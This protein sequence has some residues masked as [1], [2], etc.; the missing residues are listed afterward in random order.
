MEWINYHHLLYFWVVAREGGLVPAGK[1]LNLSHPTLSTQIRSLEAALDEKLF[2]K[3]GRKLTLTESGRI[4]FRYAEEIF[5]LG[6][7]MVDTLKGRSSGQPLRLNIGIVDSVPKLVVLRML[8]PVLGL[9]EPVKLMCFE[10]SHT[11]LLADL[12]IHSLHMVVSDSPVSPGGPIRA[13][14]HLLGESEVSFFASAPLAKRFGRDFPSSL[15]GA[16]FLLPLEHLSLRRSLDRWF[17]RLG[18]S[19]HIVAE[20]EDSAL[21]KVFGADGAGVFTAPSA[22]ESEVSRQYGVKALGRADGVTERFYAITMERRM[23]H[24]A[25]LAISHGAQSDLFADSSPLEGE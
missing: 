21:L 11:K 18:L 3:E 5:G 6:R 10:G 16:P 25:V 15:D 20:F 9:A 17:N 23:S 2:R 12:A 1:V 22:I 14:S 13:Y 19:P 8:Q 4:A 7:E 24:P